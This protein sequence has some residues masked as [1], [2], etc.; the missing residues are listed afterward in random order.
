MSRV[1]SRQ[2]LITLLYSAVFRYPLSASEVWLRLVRLPQSK[3]ISPGKVEDALQDL[4]GQGVVRQA[5]EH[6]FPTGTPTIISRAERREWSLLKAQEAKRFAQFAR[7]IPWVQAVGIT[8]SVAVENAVE[9]DDIDFLIITSQNRLWLTRLVVT[10]I[11][12]L[13]GKRR[14]WHGEEQG[15]WCFN[16]WLTTDSLFL[17]RHLR[18]LYGAYELCQVRW[19]FSRGGVVSQFIEKNNWVRGYLPTYFAELPRI[20][21]VSTGETKF[22]PGIGLLNQ[23]SYLFQSWYMRPHRTSEQVGREYALFHP[24]ATRSIIQKLLE[25]RIFQLHDTF[26]DQ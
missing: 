16:M 24:R 17:P 20:H 12:F 11:A 10:S 9:H 26:S 21:H 19:I 23:L 25:T 5:G 2:V 1:L 7:H 4:R 6:Y 3:H 18:T 13:S 8:G 14:S 22:F 15:S